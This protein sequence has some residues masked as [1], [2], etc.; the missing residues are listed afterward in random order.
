MSGLKK[1]L[2]AFLL[3]L[4]AEALAVW[5]AL[6]LTGSFTAIT[7]LLSAIAILL[8]MGVVAVVYVGRPVAG[9]VRS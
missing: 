3:T 5:I 2:V 6:A 7:M 9:H 8:F 1:T 4:L